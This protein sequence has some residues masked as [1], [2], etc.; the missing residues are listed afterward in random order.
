MPEKSKSK[1]SDQAVI[2]PKPQ[3][4]RVT[5]DLFSTVGRKVHREIE[6]P[7][8]KPYNVYRTQL[9]SNSDI[10]FLPLWTTS[11]S[12]VEHD[13]YHTAAWELLVALERSGLPYFSLDPSPWQ[14]CKLLHGGRDNIAEGASYKIC[15]R[16]MKVKEQTKLV[17]VK[18]IKGSLLRSDRGSRSNNLAASG[19]HTIRKDIEVMKKLQHR[20]QGVHPHVLSCLGYG[21]NASEEGELSAFL[22]VPLAHYG[23]LREFLQGFEISHPMKK[24]I[25]TQICLG[26]RSLHLYEIVHGDIKMENVLVFKRRYL[27]TE[28]GIR[29]YEPPRREFPQISPIAKNV[30]ICLSDFGC[31]V[32]TSRDKYFGTTAYNAPEVRSGAI[33]DMSV[34]DNISKHMKCDMFS[35]GLLLLEILLDGQSIAS[36]DQVQDM[37]VRGQKELQALHFALDLVLQISVTLKESERERLMFKELYKDIFLSTL[38]LN[39]DLRRSVAHLLDLIESVQWR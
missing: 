24:E 25:F 20:K 32:A 19:L 39:P 17:A 23:T 5:E 34:Q 8:V 1:S 37:D 29:N 21:W 4:W 11:F 35:C 7:K 16:L 2:P 15:T 28:E 9:Y 31:S 12:D 26:L 30:H 13:T 36:N 6:S 14:E 38:R 27:E 10:G 22:V 3:F 18:V 33:N